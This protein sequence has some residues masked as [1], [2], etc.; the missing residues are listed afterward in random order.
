M[1][2]IAVEEHFVARCYM[3]YLRSRKDYPR[4]EII[5]DDRHGKIERICH[6]PLITRARYPDVTNRVAD[7]GEGRLS[8]MNDAG[9]DM[10][11]LSMAFPRE[12]LLD[13]SDAITMARAVNDEIHEVTKKNPD[14]FAGF[15]TLTRHDPDEAAREFERAVKKLGLK[16]AFFTSHFNGEY[17]DDE[18]YLVILEAAA[19]LNAPIYLHPREPSPDMIKPY[20]DYPMLARTML[21][22]AAEASLHAMRLICSGVFDRLPNLKI[23]LGHLGE[24]L[25]FWLWRMDNVWV[26][27]RVISVPHNKKLEKLPSQYIKDNFFVTTSG[28][29]WEAALMCVLLAL[30]AERILF[31]VDYPFEFSEEAV[32]FLEKAPISISDKEKIYHLNTEKLLAL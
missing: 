13:R 28:M 19:R 3:D 31:A 1:K 23:I 29:F 11:V 4:L 18:K 6:S 2:R 14:R 30:G 25:P 20:L 24:A 16:G 10:Q 22:F 9:I 21:G 7:L 15:S 32:Q 17:L 26:N 27:E 12:E 8:H 5:E